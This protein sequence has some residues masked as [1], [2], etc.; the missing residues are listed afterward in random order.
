MALNCSLTTCLSAPK[1]QHVIDANACL[2]AGVAFINCIPVFIASDD[3][4]ISRFEKKGLPLIGDDVKS[5][6]GATIIHRTLAKLFMDRGVRITH[7]YQLNV[8][9][10]TDF[11]NMRSHARLKSKKI[12]KTRG[13]LLPNNAPNAG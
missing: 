10:N 1:M 8:G 13:C 7:T 6:V 2:E 5:Q 9:G 4:W 11:L 3:E 12:S